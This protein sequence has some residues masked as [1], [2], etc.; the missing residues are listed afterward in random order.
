LLDETNLHAG[1][2]CPRVRS[3]A[4]LVTQIEQGVFD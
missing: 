2:D 1:A 4:E 3:L